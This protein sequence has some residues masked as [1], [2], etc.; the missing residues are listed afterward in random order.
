MLGVKLDGPAMMFGDNMSVI[1]NTS[2]PSS[3]LRKKHHSISYHRVREAISSGAL[4]FTYVKSKNNYVDCLTK[5]LPNDDFLSLVHPL[6][7]QQPPSFV[8][9]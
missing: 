1:I 8:E 4:L 5:P 6:L 7:L 9:G 3:Q 2:I